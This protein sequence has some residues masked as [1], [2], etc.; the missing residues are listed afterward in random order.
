[1]TTKPAELHGGDRASQAERNWLLAALSEGEYVE[2]ATHLATVTLAA[3][4]QLGPAHEEVPLVY[5]PQ[6]GVVSIL[7]TMEDGTTVEV[8]TVGSEGMTALAVFLGG[9][10]MS[11]ECRVQ[12]A[13]TARRIHA[14]RLQE[15]SRVGGPL[16]EVLQC[17]T[18]YLISQMG[19][20]IACTSLHSIYQR[21][22]R[23]MLTTRDRVGSDSFVMTHDH[24]AQLLGVRRATV[25]EAAEALRR[26]GGIEYRRGRI[27]ILDARALEAM[28]CECHRTTRGD[29]ERLLGKAGR[30]LTLVG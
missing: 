7:K 16:H 12:I 5:F 15:M 25:S 9:D 27:R 18:Q 28:A 19:Q 8:G 29:F 3:G 21:F 13:G 4:Q 17:Y 20:S 30:R 2:V 10:E 22:A 1:M 26:A 14:A 24:L 6:S 23:W 11:T